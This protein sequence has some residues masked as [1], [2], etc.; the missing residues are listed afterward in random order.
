M[1]HTS[2]TEEN[3]P[4]TGS[5]LTFLGELMKALVSVFKSA[6]TDKTDKLRK[7]PKMAAI[8]NVIERLLDDHPVVEDYGVQH[9]PAIKLEQTHSAYHPARFPENTTFS[10]EVTEFKPDGF[11]NLDLQVSVHAKIL[12]NRHLHTVVFHRPIVIPMRHVFVSLQ[13][14]I[15]ATEL[16]GSLRKSI[17]F[18][19]SRYIGD[20][21]SLMVHEDEGRFLFQLNALVELDKT[22]GYQIANVNEIVWAL[23]TDFR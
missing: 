6:S 13:S 1:S 21:F 9:Y 8:K 10:V 22:G 15:V 18:A 16:N 4:S 3:G 17:L 14:L 5:L 12:G 2:R 20:N 11:D 7:R 23:P 19:S